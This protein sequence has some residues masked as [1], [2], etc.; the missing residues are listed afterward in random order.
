MTRIRI[1]CDQSD[2]TTVTI[3]SIS[4]DEGEEMIYSANRSLMQ[5]NYRDTVTLALLRWITHLEQCA[6]ISKQT[7]GDEQ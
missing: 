5:D 4:D 7:H 2:G 1:M 3:G 6:Q